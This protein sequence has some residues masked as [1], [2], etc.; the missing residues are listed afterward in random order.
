M[1]G[2]FNGYGASHLVYPDFIA[3]YLEQGYRTPLW[4]PDLKITP[5]ILEKQN[6]ALYYEEACTELKSIGEHYTD[7]QKKRRKL[8]NLYDTTLETQVITSWC[9]RHCATFANV[10]A[11]LTDT[12]I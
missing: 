12:S 7:T 4:Y 11:H 9:E 10:I 6:C 1:E 8:F 3:T 5:V 2:H